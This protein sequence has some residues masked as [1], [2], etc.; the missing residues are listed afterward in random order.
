VLAYLAAL[1]MWW[2]TPHNKLPLALLTLP[3]AVQA[4]WAVARKDGA[5]LN[6]ELGRTARLGLLFNLA[7]TIGVLA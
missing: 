4:V 3:L 7:L 5:A 6:D 1:A 2:L